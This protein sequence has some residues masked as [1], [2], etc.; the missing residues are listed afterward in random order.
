MLAA[1]PSRLDGQGVP[2]VRRFLTG[3]VNCE[4]TGV[5]TTPDQRTMFINLQ[6]PGEGGGSTWPRLDGMTVPRSSTVVITKDDGGVIG[7]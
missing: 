4:V 6:H 3:V 7:T 2:E 1:D 5:I